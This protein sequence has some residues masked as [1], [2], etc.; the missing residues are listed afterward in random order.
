MSK[1]AIFL[2]RDGVVNKEVNYLN[3]IDDFEFIN[4]IFDS[5]LHFLDLG[6]EIIII[7]NQ[8]GIDRGYLSINDYKNIT[9]WMTKQFQEKNIKILDIFYC[10]HKPES[11]CKCRK[12]RPGMLI[13]AKT[14]HNINMNQSWMIGDKE[15]DIQ[16]ANSAG[17]NNTILVK[18]GH[19]IDQFNSNA[20]FILDSIK[21]SKKIITF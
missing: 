14:K 20:K 4:G 3:N 2:D 9:Q 13:E 1:K 7:T 11:K 19:I 18:S 5:C 21:E 6:Y 17:I 10:P 12:P 8:S 15:N 16:A